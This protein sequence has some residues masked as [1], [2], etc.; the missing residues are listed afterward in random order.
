VARKKKKKE[1]WYDMPARMVTLLVVVA[2]AIYVGYINGDFLTGLVS[3][4]ALSL[5][6]HIILNAIGVNTEIKKWAKS[7]RL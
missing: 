1:P 2:G 6:G 5:I 3:L 4:L 7:H